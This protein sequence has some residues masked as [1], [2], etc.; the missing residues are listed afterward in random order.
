VTT[1]AVE[2]T[3]GRVQTYVKRR[4]VI[5]IVLGTHGHQ[6]AL[7]TVS[8]LIGRHHMATSLLR[9]SQLGLTAIHHANRRLGVNVIKP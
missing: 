8:I 4:I 6:E 1:L 7:T 5:G 3:L 2:G 9:R